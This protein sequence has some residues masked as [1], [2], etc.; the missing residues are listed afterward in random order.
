M[1]KKA[2]KAKRERFLS[3]FLKSEAVALALSAAFA[4]G[5]QVNMHRRLYELSKEAIGEEMTRLQQGIVNRSAK[6]DDPNVCLQEVNNY[7]TM[8][9]YFD[10]WVDA[11]PFLERI[12]PYA[13]LQPNYTPKMH[14]V[15]VLMDEDGNIAAS[16][17]LQ[18]QSGLIFNKGKDNDGY[19]GIYGCSEADLACPAVEELYKDYRELEGNTIDSYIEMKVDDFYINKKEHK[20]VPHKGT[21]SKIKYKTRGY[22]E[23]EEIGQA[24]LI[25]QTDINTVETR[26]F[27]IELNDKDYE[28]TDVYNTSITTG[29]YPHYYLL[30]FFGEEQSV[31]ERFSD[32][33]CSPDDDLFY[34]SECQA[35]GD[36]TYT[37]GRNTELY[38]N[39]Q[40]YYFYL[41]NVVNFKD[42]QLIKY[43]WINTLLVT[44]I[45]M[46]IAWLY[47]WRRNV[48][49]KAHYELEDYQRD[50][51]NDL[52][53]DIKTP[54]MAIGGYAENLLE[55]E[56]TED[57]KK[58]YL[59]SILDNVTYTDSIITRTIDLNSMDGKIKPNKEKFEISSIAEN[60]IEKYALMLENG[61]ITV[62]SNGKAELIADKALTEM[63]VEN[64]ISNAIKYVSE[65]GKI[66]IDI[67]PKS[68]VITNTVSSKVDT[69]DLKIPFH[70]G[71]KSRTGKLGSGLGL[72]IADKACAANSFALQ[73][74]CT[75]TEFKAEVL[76]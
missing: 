3:I 14:S 7:L 46:A 5:F 56:L 61:N 19:R 53:H 31:I 76:F 65:N 74:K 70:K 55:V 73:L 59:K 16:N 10:V 27:N 4:V 58:R 25:D 45:L 49:N 60:I 17:R 9:T 30:N 20:F 22:F 48:M 36:G 6:Y 33:Y 57:E 35:N 13:V 32:S 34:S 2:R 47:S 63:I 18:L 40:K 39:N 21:M 23:D 50:L 24:Y 42:A 8:Y 52:A 75:D 43:F 51:T 11:N 41:R 26:E 64:L 68:F 29:P 69:K 62:T 38:I 66:A 44:A 71:D 1:K 37:F 67:K 54:L 12:M 15:S 72:S 28:L